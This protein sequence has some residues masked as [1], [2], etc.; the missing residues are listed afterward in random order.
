MIDWMDRAAC[1]GLEPEDWYPNPSDTLSREEAIAVCNRCPVKNECNEWADDNRIEYGVWGGVF[2]EP[3]LK[4]PVLSSLSH[5]VMLQRLAALIDAYDEHPAYVLDR[6]GRRI[7][8]ARSSMGY[9]AQWA[10]SRGW[11]DAGHSGSRVSGRPTPA[12]RRAVAL[13]MEG[14]TA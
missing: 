1:V 8:V 2:R 7:G 3:P 6:A 9:V 14:A 11:W 12:G 5:R 4:P 13:V 10:A